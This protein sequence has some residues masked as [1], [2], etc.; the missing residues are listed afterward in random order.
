VSIPRFFSIVASVCFVNGG[1]RAEPHYFYPQ[2][3]ITNSIDVT[4]P[5]SEGIT[6]HNHA[7]ECLFESMFTVAGPISLNGGT[8]TLA[9]DLYCASSGY[10]QTAGI[11]NGQGRIC[12]FPYRA[13]PF[14]LPQAIEYTGIR[15]VKKISF[16]QRMG[17]LSWHTQPPDGNK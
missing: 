1:L 6:L 15:S 12:A 16:S 17:A 5:C 8:L 7:T 9:Q 14:L 13:D 4:T 2:N 10:L 11:L 3:N